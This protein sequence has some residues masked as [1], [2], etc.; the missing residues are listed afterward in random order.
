MKLFSVDV[1]FREVVI[2]RLDRGRV[3]LLGEPGVNL[4]T[5]CHTGCSDEIY[6]NLQRLGRAAGS[7]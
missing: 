3:L 4:K 2:A 7:L 1:N 5:F 6:Y